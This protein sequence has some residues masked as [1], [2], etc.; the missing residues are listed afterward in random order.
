VYRS[1]FSKKWDFADI[2]A[3]NL[4]FQTYAVWFGWTSV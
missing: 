2:Q 1:A 3:S 4:T